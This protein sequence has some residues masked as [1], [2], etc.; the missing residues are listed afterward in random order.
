MPDATLDDV[1]FVSCSFLQA[2]D[3]EVLLFAWIAL[4]VTALTQ[5]AQQLQCLWLF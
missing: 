1:S 2:C 4:L 3:Y 5:V